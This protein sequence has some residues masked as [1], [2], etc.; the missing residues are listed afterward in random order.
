[1]AISFLATLMNALHAV[2]CVDGTDTYLS[3]LKQAQHLHA[4]P[5]PCSP[6][7]IAQTFEQT[8]H[9]TQRVQAVLLITENH[10]MDGCR[11]SHNQHKNSYLYI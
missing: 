10:N 6:L 8:Q 11:L 2:S 9:T 5:L 1:V 3:E 7:A 4:L